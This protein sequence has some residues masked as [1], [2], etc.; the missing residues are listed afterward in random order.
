MMSR[1]IFY[2]FRLLPSPLHPTS[3]GSDLNNRCR[4]Y[5]WRGL[6]EGYIGEHSTSYLWVMWIA[7]VN[8]VHMLIL[9]M[10]IIMIKAFSLFESILKTQESIYL[11]LFNLFLFYSCKL[12]WNMQITMK[13]ANYNEAC[14]FRKLNSM[15]QAPEYS[16]PGKLSFQIS[17]GILDSIDSF[18]LLCQI[19]IY[20]AQSTEIN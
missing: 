5:E 11:K 9:H 14:V 10:L 3:I 6:L 12:Q 1:Y 15:Q 7:G 8:G 20:L 2:T 19:S 16:A 18:R 13:H 17:P 4:V